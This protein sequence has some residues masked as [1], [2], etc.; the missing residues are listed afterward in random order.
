MRSLLLALPV[1]FAAASCGATSTTLAET[2]VGPETTVQDEIALEVAQETA[3]EA[4]ATEPSAEDPLTPAPWTGAF[5]ETAVM[6]AGTIYV[7]GPQGLLEHVAARVDDAYFQRATE[8]TDQGF[9]QTIVRPSESVPEI[10]VRLDRWTMAAV[11]RVVILER[12]D[13]CPVTVVATGDAIWR[14]VDGI[15]SRSARLEFVGHIGQDDPVAPTSITSASDE[16]EGTEETEQ[17]D[18]T[19]GEAPAPR[20]EEG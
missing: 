4:P 15:I 1:A 13:E 16:T 6:L 10:R 11:S 20:G 2:P 17:P 8:T 3:T 7:E 12:F 19:T 18:A 9:L 14:D 5:S